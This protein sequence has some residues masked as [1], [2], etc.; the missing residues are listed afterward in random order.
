MDTGLACAF[1]RSHW[2]LLKDKS[3][4]ALRHG[5]TVLGGVVDS[6]YRGRIQVIL[7][8]SGSRPVTI[9]QYT[10]MCQAILIPQARGRFQDGPIDMATD[11]GSQASMFHPFNSSPSS[12]GNGPQQ[13]PR[14]P[15]PRF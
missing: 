7:H 12:S 9:P 8:N 3:S 2:C 15:G 11:R 14:L 5:L 6:N 1:P 4:L 10:A 13:A